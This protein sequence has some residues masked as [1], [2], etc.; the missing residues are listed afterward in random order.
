MAKKISIDVTD[1]EANALAKLINCNK[2]HLVIR[3]KRAVLR[4]MEKLRRADHERSH[5]EFLE[6]CRG[7]PLI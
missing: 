7:E 5:I 4:V 6:S 2:Q 1:I 3:D